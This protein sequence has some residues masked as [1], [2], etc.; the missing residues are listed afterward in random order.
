MKFSLA[1][2]PGPS[3]FDQWKDAMKA[4]NRLPM[5]I[6]PDFRKK[7]WLSLA[8]RYVRQLKVDWPNTVRLA[9]N[10]RS[11]PDDDKLGL[12]IVK[13]LHRT[14]CS[15]FSGQA[16]DED[17]AV[18]KRV[19]LAY[20]RWNKRIGYCQGFN[21][22][23]AL[24]LD[25][26]DRK[27]DDAFKVMVFLVDH[28]LPES[29]FD[30]NLR[31]LS[32]DLAVFR[33]LLR[34]TLPALADHL[35]HLQHLAPD[36]GTGACYEPPL[37]NVLTLQWF[38]TLF[39]TC[40]PRAAV[41]RVWDTI[42]LEGSEV[43]LRTA[44]CLWTK[45]ARRIMGVESADE[46]YSL[47]GEM[48]ADMME[49][50]V[51]HGDHIIKVRLPGDHIMLPG[52]HIMLPGDHIIK[53][54]LPGDHIIKVRLPG[55][56]I[57]LPGDHIMLPGDHIIKVRL[58][59]DHIIKVRLP[60]DHIMLPGD[61]IMLPGDHIIKVRLPGDHIIK[62][63]LPG[64]HII[65]VKLPGDH[66][67]LP[68]DHIIKVRLP[69]D[70]IIKVRLPGDHIMLPGDHIIKAIYA[71]APFPFP[72]LSQ[73][74]EKYTYNI[75]P[76]TP[77][78]PSP[79][80][81]RRLSRLAKALLSS[82]DDEPDEEEL[83]ALAALPAMAVAPGSKAKNTDISVVGPGVFGGE[84]EA[85]S[86]GRD[87]GTSAVYM[88]RMST[89]LG[90][91]RQHYNRLRQRQQQAHVVITAAVSAKKA[92]EVKQKSQA[93]VPVMMP[94]M[95]T[96]NH[97]YVA[98]VQGRNRMAR[99]VPGFTVDCV[100][101]HRSGRTTHGH[102]A[103]TLRACSWTS[104]PPHTP[105]VGSGSTSSSPE[106]EGGIIPRTLLECL[107]E[108]A[109][110]CEQDPAWCKGSPS[111][112]ADCGAHSRSGERHAIYYGALVSGSPHQACR[113][114]RH[115]PQ[116]C[117]LVS[118]NS[119]SG[120]RHGHDKQHPR[121]SPS[122]EV[123]WAALRRC[124]EGEE[125]EPPQSPVCGREDGPGDTDSH[126]GLTQTD[127]RSG[128]GLTHLGPD[129]EDDPSSPQGPGVR[130]AVPLSQDGTTTTPDPDRWANR[131][132]GEVQSQLITSSAQ[133][134]QQYSKQRAHQSNDDH[135]PLTEGSAPHKTGGRPF[136]VKQLTASRARTGLKLGLYTPSSLHLTQG[137]GLGE[138]KSRRASSLS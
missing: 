49:G 52:D 56:H 31:A 100:L 89:D 41:L 40:L 66:I 117:A 104:S 88:E 58:P 69:G 138:K 61:H 6:P 128:E 8:D 103:T 30:N 134:D 53:V 77:P 51:D 54:R 90:A 55:D 34:M 28:V 98:K 35:D 29:F 102:A 57:M 120:H 65:K 133:S 19:L 81:A 23:V 24:L 125:G 111:H 42:L 122:G 5:G 45:L 101:G 37:T 107:E 72:R 39:A 80:P 130:G 15:S 75:R 62:V 127:G 36:H 16:N 22:I 119:R 64:D 124:E 33:D 114:A 109:T 48:S 113:G 26:M 44:L 3:A 94:A 20:A 9:F 50:G 131:R 79:S 27:E 43:L 92:M 99:T 11:N 78:S 126:D 60:G 68:G 12:Q 118:K 129:E 47:M 14:G 110:L 105:S 121:P 96:M 59:G 112:H 71:L 108:P 87:S 115:A 67:M 17:R 135:A 7:V 83:R 95:Q 84:P 73:L 86:G 1:P 70:H 38:L 13:D 10:D 63:R 106:R 97:L 85:L 76:F 132:L 93:P 123:H 82:D 18:L 4:V 25:V 32:V 46:F 2:P 136:A 21:V 74:R 116:D 91:L 137:V